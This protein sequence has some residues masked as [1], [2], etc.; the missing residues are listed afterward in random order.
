MAHLGAAQFQTELQGL[1]VNVS[2]ETISALEAYAALL[3]KWQKAI[4]LVSGATLDDLWR[5]HF[6]DSAQLLPLLPEGDGPLTDL[7]SGAGFPGLVLALLTGRPTHLVESDQRKAAFLGEVA[8]AT[9]CAGR[10]QIHAVRVEALKPWISP[11]ITARAL[12][13]L[14]QLLDWASPFLSTASICIFPKG[15]KAEDELTAALRVWKMKAERVRSVTDPTGLILRLSHLER[16]G[17]T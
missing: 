7:G 17:Q 16:R 14:T 5:R 3:R 9:G 4:N 2:R 8:R 11:V 15:A 1:G 13:D 6:L 12:A 10:V